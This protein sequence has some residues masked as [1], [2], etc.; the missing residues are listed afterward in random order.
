MTY[1]QVI[2]KM[3]DSFTYYQSGPTTGNRYGGWRYYAGENDSD[4][5]TTQWGPISYLF[6]AQVPGVTIPN[7]TVKSALQAYLTA[8]QYTNVTWPGNA[9]AVDYQPASYYIINNTHI[10]GFLVSN[11]FAGGGGSVA[12]ALA[13][14]NTH[15]KDS[16]SG[17]WYGNE[18]NPYAM[19]AVYKGLETL[20]GTTGAGPI[21]NLNP[22]GSN[23]IDPS[24]TWN[25]WE[26]YCQYL[27]DTQNHGGLTD[28]SWSGYDY[29]TGPLATA[30][31]INILNATATVQ[32]P[33]GTPEPATMLLLGLGLAGL[34]GFRRKF[35]E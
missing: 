4:M 9:G 32:P 8:S 16:A 12:N 31:D 27:V 10:G 2:Q 17:T 30:W 6:A 7:G 19:W 15:W 11:Y 14:L 18:G 29:W 5:S 1:T 35:K 13:W 23:L 21:T 33:T 24:A 26:D 22:Q 34:A 25:W 20:F 3:V 28:G